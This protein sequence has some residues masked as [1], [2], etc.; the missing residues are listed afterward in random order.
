MEKGEIMTGATRSII[1]D[2]HSLD[3]EGRSNGR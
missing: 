1:E 2:L 3:I